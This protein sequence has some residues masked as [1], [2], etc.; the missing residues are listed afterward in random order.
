VNLAVL[1]SHEGPTLQ[2]VL[3]A[4][5]HGAIPARVALVIS[6]N[7]GSGALRRAARSQVD[8]LHLSGATHPQEPELD[9][10]ILE[11]LRAH[12]IDLVLLAGYM[13][14]LGPTVLAAYRGRILNTHPAL[15]PRFGGRGMYGA[16]VHRAVLAAGERESGATVHLVEADYDSGPVL[17]QVRVPVEPGDSPESLAKRVQAAERAQLVALLGAIA[18]GTRALPGDA[19]SRP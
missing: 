6:N 15:L 16:H 3:D 17:A 5:A 14:R 7:A 19:P 13:K 1:A 2:A 9:R 11:A 8:F 10:A 4:C 18:N 12:H